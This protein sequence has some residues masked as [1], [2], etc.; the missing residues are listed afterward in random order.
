MSRNAD[1]RAIPFNRPFLAGRELDYLAEAVGRRDLAGD[2]AFTARCRAWLERELGAPMALLTHSC[3]A[4]LELAALL[5]G[6]EPGNEVI[7]SSFTYPSTANAFVLRGATPRFVDI[8]P[9]TLNLDERLIERAV[10][11]RTRAIVPVHYAGVACDM[12][13]INELAARHGVWVIEDAAL[14]VGASVDGRF[15]GT[16]G[17]LGCYSFHQTKAFH[18][19]EGGALLVNDERFRARAEILR[20][21][22]TD[23]SRFLRGEV[24]RYT[25]V[26]VGSSY[27][28]SELVAAFLYAQLEA[29]TET[30]RA[31]QLVIDRYH[32]GL[33]DLAERGLLSL[34][35]TPPGCRPNAQMFHVLVRDRATRD[36]LLDDLA[37][38]G[39]RA[40]FHY[41]PLHTSAMGA[42]FG[43]RAGDLPVTERASSR[44][45]RL[46]CYPEL[47][48]PDQDRV[49]AAVT[50][51]LDA[52]P[53]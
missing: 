50:R 11:S 28:P 17:H 31:R 22:G 42:R 46:P 51:S 35:I 10:G 48:P 33:G 36:R 47:A 21:K 45:V 25:W 39:I 32:D 18:A 49:I 24:D 4:A 9:D 34:P 38:D 30:S 19:G 13:A 26:D 3:T 37:A 7:L 29:S 14:A 44:L 27:L 5:I 15:L 20:D 2:G 53:A 23:R 6:V 43:Y 40:T 16:I 12:E 52:G 8:R 41:L 1:R